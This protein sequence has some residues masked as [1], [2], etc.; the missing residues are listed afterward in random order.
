MPPPPN[1]PPQFRVIAEML[2]QAILQE[3]TARFPGGFV[4]PRQQVIVDSEDEDGRPVRKVVTL[5]QQ[6]EDLI[7]VARKIVDVEEEAL[8]VVHRKQRRPR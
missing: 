4:D 6:L 7:V 8:E 5:H 1:L 3:F 2:G